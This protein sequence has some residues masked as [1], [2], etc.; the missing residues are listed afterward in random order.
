VPFQFRPA[1]RDE[2]LKEKLVIEY[3]AILRWAID[4]WLDLKANGRCRPVSPA[5]PKNTS[6]MKT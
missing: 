1:T 2:Q 4:G 6:T 3:P 5:R